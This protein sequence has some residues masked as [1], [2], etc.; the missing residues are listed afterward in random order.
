MSNGHEVIGADKG[1]LSSDD[2]GKKSSAVTL[3]NRCIRNY[4]SDCNG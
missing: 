1:Y 3:S 2:V 4:N